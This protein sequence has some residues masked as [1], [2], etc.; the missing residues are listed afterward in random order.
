MPA[1]ERFDLR[2]P[3]IDEGWSDP[4]DS[5]LK[6]L[7]RLFGFGKKKDDGK[8]KKDWQGIELARRANK[9]KNK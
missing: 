6:S 5:P 4:T 9:G 1:G 7:G 2:S 8:E 3:W